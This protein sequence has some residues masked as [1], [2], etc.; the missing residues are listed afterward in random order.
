[1]MRIDMLLKEKYGF[2]RQ[3]AQQLIKEGAV[4]LNGAV[5]MKPSVS[6]DE[7]DNVEM[8]ENDVLKYVGRGGLKLEGAIKSFGLDLKDMVCLDIGASTGGFTDCMLQNGAKYVYAVDVGTAQLADS[9]KSDKRVASFENTDIS[10]FS[11]REN[12][13]FIACDVSFVSLSKILPHIDR[14]LGGKNAVVLVKPQFEAGREHLSKS[15]VVRDVKVHKKVLER[16]VSEAAQHG[17]FC[18][19]IEVSPIKGGD[20]NTEY[21]MLLERE[22]RLRSVSEDIKRVTGNG[23]KR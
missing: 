6:A 22:N 7:N 1:M 8:L 2:S 13:G 17:L 9:L 10:D 15:G 23:S 18:G 5:V 21:L 16:I 4:K 3:K 12:I 11:C 19:G 14:L 20:G